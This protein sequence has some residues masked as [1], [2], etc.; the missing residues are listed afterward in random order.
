[1]DL[2]RRQ[3]GEQRA[4]RSE[5]RSLYLSRSSQCGAGGESK[6]VGAGVGLAPGRPQ[7]P[8]NPD[9]NQ[10][11]APPEDKIRVIP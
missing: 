1:M 6:R 9:P 3:V 7:N 10:T 5:Q 2:G 8:A 11:A 4:S